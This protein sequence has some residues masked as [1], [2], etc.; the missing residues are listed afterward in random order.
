MGQLEFPEGFVWGTASSSYQIEGAWDEDGKGQS[1][2]D[3]F[4]HTPGHVIDCS[5]GDVAT[6]H[7]HRWSEDVAL[8][9]DLGLTAYR[10]S[11][12]WP[13]IL[14]EGR[15]QVNQAGLDH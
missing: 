6:D 10:F 7:C 14:P 11:V 5:T 15:R 8:M 2:W 12:S 13:R 1:I 4:T 3:R 9:K